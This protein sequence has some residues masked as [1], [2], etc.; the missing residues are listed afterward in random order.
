DRAN[1]W[2]HARALNKYASGIITNNYL[3]VYL[4]R[5]AEDKVEIEYLE[6]LAEALEVKDSDELV[7]RLFKTAELVADAQ[8]ESWAKLESGPGSLPE[9]AREYYSSHAANLAAA[10]ILRSEDEREENP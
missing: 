9:S 2:P 10:A 4:A 3:R 8:A 7:D 5:A 6:K 1:D